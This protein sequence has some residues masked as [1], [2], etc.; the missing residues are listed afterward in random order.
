[1][2]CL[3]ASALAIGLVGCAPQRSPARALDTNSE[4][5]ISAR[6]YERGIELVRPLAY[7]MLID[8]GFDITRSDPLGDEQS[9]EAE[10]GSRTVRI[11]LARL[12]ARE[13]WMFAQA[14]D[15]AT[16]ADAE[17]AQRVADG[18]ARRLVDQ[19]TS[20]GELQ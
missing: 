2:K 5:G 13:T 4:T 6:S 1:M 15:A 19:R 11:E 7:A 16:G 10:D 9:L 20:K 12:G 8:L 3:L 14:S 18:I 17:L